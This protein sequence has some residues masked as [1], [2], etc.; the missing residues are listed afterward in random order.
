[1]FGDNKILK[2]TQLS[3]PNLSLNKREEQ[4]G[5]L[6]YPKTNKLVTALYMVTDIMDI[7]EPVRS[8][9]R[10]LG[11]DIVSDIHFLASSTISDIDKRIS[12]ILSFLEISFNLNMISEM[13]YSILKKEFLELKESLIKQNNPAWLEEFFKEE[14]LPLLD[15]EGLG[16]GNLKDNSIGHLKGHQTRIGVQKGSTLMQA[17]SDKMTSLSDTKNSVLA[18]F[19]ILKQKRQAE[20]INLIKLKDREGATIT[21]IKNE[22]QKYS[23]TYIN[24][25]SCSEKTLQRELVF[26]VHSDVLYKT[27]EKRWS[28]YF[29]K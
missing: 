28:R 4:R 2:D 7:T 14:K 11:A 24:L 25:V 10:I 29:V 19:E 17:L 9:L 16:G 20:I 12:T 27:G 1:M 3:S 21:D 22:V 5:G 13:N 18:D 15:K 23:K 8:K 26:M 6:S